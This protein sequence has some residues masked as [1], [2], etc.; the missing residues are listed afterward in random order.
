[1]YIRTHT[2]VHLL[3]SRVMKGPVVAWAARTWESSSQTLPR[4]I[5]K[6]WVIWSPLRTLLLLLCSLRVDLGFYRVYLTH[7]IDANTYRGLANI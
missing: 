5:E 6:Q 3:V 4:L 2:L 7:L 1:M